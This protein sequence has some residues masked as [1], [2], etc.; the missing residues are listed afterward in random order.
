M[1]SGWEGGRA[2]HG[3]ADAQGVHLRREGRHASGQ[4]RGRGGGVGMPPRWPSFPQS[5]WGPGV[6]DAQGGWQGPGKDGGWR[7]PQDGSRPPPELRLW[8]WDT[9]VRGHRP[10]VRAVTLNS[11][12]LGCLE[13]PEALASWTRS[14][15]A[16]LPAPR[17]L[18]PP[19]RRLPGQETGQCCWG[20]RS[21][22][23]ALFSFVITA[24]WKVRHFSYPCL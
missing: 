3:A 8:C 17:P 7:L 11:G 2:G 22:R 10:S 21:F 12:S 15:A 14:C 1:A 18:G 19:T 9:S 24:K 23:W 16:S 5:F 20:S 13:N 6:G 4:L